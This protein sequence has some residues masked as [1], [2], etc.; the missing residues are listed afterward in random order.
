MQAEQS[1]YSSQRVHCGG[2]S[3]RWRSPPP[4]SSGQGSRSGSARN[5]QR[6]RDGHQPQDWSDRHAKQDWY[7]E[8][9]PERNGS[10]NRK[11]ISYREIGGIE[12]EWEK[13]TSS[14]LM[15]RVLHLSIT[16]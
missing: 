14:I 13:Q 1:L 7:P 16:V 11:E 5:R 4:W 10:K 8:Q 12:R 3:S 15:L 6:P 2:A 9:E